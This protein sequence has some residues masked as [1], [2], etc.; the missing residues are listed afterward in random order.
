VSGMSHCHDE[1]ASRLSANCMRLQPATK[2][3]DVTEAVDGI[4]SV[5]NFVG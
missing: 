4:V 2:R 5:S 1:G 3:R